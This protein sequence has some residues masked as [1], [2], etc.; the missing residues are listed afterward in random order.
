MIS[1]LLSLESFVALANATGY[2][3]FYAAFFPAGVGVFRAVS[4]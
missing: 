3:R 2:K 4:K 1:L